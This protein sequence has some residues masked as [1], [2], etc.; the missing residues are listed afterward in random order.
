M[1]ETLSMRSTQSIDMVLEEMIG[2]KRI[3]LESMSQSIKQGSEN[4]L[5][6]L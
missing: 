1:I 5:Q 3:N 6:F 4:I 2:M